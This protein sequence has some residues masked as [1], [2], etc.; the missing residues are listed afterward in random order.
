MCFRTDNAH[1]TRLRH[2]PLAFQHVYGCCNESENGEVVDRTKIK[3][4]GEEERMKIF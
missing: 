4:S 2:N 1:E 3:I